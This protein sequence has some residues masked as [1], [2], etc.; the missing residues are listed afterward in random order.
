VTAEL[1]SFMQSD[2][3]TPSHGV[4]CAPFLIPVPPVHDIH[5]FFWYYMHLHKY[6]DISIDLSRE[7]L[8]I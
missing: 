8:G 4:T 6:V 5:F 3:R 7:E 1:H 2:Y